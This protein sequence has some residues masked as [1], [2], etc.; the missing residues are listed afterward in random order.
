M[1]EARSSVSLRLSRFLAC[2]YCRNESHS[3]PD[4]SFLSKLSIKE[5]KEKS[6]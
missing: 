4:D 1:K 5:K 2:R 3:S 6:L